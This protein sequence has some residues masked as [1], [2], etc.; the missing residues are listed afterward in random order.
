MYEISQP[1]YFLLGA[2][3]LTGL[4]SCTAFITTLKLLV[5]D[6]KISGSSRVF[7]QMRGVRIVLPFGGTAIGI[8]IFLASCL[9]IFAF[10]AQFAYGFAIPLTLLLAALVWF[11]LTRLF[12]QLEQGGVKAINIDELGLGRIIPQSKPNRE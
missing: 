6:W 11:Q 12:D 9:Q 5:K 10:S 8:G 1:P 4:I 7:S 3:L 2:G